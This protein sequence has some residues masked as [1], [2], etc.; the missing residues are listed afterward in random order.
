MAAQFRTP[1]L[2]YGENVSYEYGGNAGEETYSARNQ[3]ENGA[4]SD[5][6]REDLLVEGLTENDLTMLNAPPA[7]V[8]NQL[9]PFYLSYFVPWNSYKNYIFAQKRG[10][11]DLTHEW[12]RTNHAENFDQIDSRGYLIH[13]WLKYPKFGHAF[14][15]DYTSRFIRY[16]MM[17]REEAIKIVRE[18]DS[19]VDPLM[20][21]D[22]CEFCGY[23]EAEFWAIVDRL[24]NKEIFIKNE[25]GEWEL[26]NPL[27]KE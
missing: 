14:A 20:V 21:R 17:N 5:M 18:R 26:K 3:L 16:G 13:S 1:M 22:F 6:S 11:R 2:C 4:A 9:D 12:Q 7:E 24:Y 8:M 23:T 19:N 27:G 25:Y 10:F 15:T